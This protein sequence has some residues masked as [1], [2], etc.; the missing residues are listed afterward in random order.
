MGHHIVER[1][2]GLVILLGG[3]GSLCHIEVGRHHKG[4]TRVVAQIFLERGRPLAR[5]VGALGS[6]VGERVEFAHG[7][8]FGQPHAVEVGGIGIDGIFLDIDRLEVGHGHTGLFAGRIALDYLLVG[9]Y[10]LVG[11]AVVE[12]DHAQL[13]AALAGYRALGIVVHQLAV[14]G[15]GLV[16][17]V[18]YRIGLS[19]FEPGIGQITRA[20]I[21]GDELVEQFDF[22][23]L[24]FLQPG[25]ECLLEE[26]VVAAGR[27]GLLRLCVILLGIGIATGVVVAVAGTGIGIG[28][29]ALVGPR[30]CREV[31]REAVERLR[32][33]VL[34]ELAIG[35]VVPG[36]G[37]HLAALVL[38]GRE[39]CRVVAGRGTVLLLTIQALGEPERSL[40]AD[41]G[42]VVA[43]ADS[44]GEK[45][46]GLLDAGI[47]KRLGTQL[48]QDALLGGQY[49]AVGPL[50]LL[51]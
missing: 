39:E 49:L 16:V 18:E 25:H 38:A 2:E 23:L 43:H 15:Y 47:G 31:T 35:P 8:L 37:I 27:I 21:L 33:V 36:Q 51:D 24:I 4:P 17:A 32:E 19:L 40:G 7:C 13:Q 22:T 29:H 26:G 9:G 46:P 48:E 30:L 10:R 42:I 14:A 12:V 34:L 6:H 41:V 45:L 44:L 50:Y 5:H 3:K 11:L 1:G 20:G 28:H